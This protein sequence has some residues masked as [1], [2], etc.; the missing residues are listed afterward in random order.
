[1]YSLS[2]R[3]PGRFGSGHELSQLTDRGDG[4]GDVLGAW[5]AVLALFV[6]LASCFG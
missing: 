5:I 6:A 2:G 4:P 3:S 1:M